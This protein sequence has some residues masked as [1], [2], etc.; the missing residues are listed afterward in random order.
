MGWELPEAQRTV[1]LIGA[2]SYG[3]T[4]KQLFCYLWY[5][6]SNGR[7]ITMVPVTATPLPE[8]A[9]LRLFILY[10]ISD[11]MVYLRNEFYF[12][13]VYRC[14]NYFGLRAK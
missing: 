11:I 12:S 10:Q 9:T 14:G 4:D 2:K 13:V 1:T 5:Q 3:K 8:G 6:P 7:N